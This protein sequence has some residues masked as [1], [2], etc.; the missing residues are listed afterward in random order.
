MWMVLRKEITE[1]L[2]DRRTLRL[3]ILM[4]AVIMPLMMMGVPSFFKMRVESEG[5]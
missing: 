4:P 2:R 1:L 3:M 5:D